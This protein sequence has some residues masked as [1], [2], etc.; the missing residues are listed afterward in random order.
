MAPGSRT[1]RV[2]DAR[3]KFALTQAP[4]APGASEDEQ[5]KLFTEAFDIRTQRRLA[6]KKSN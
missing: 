3:T 4:L 2:R 5:T 6:T 1:P